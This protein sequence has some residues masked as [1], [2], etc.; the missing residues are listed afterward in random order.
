MTHVE[1][2]RATKKSQILKQTKR[3]AWCL[4]LKHLNQIIYKNQSTFIQ[5]KYFFQKTLGTI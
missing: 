5:L 3:G 4:K 1:E 2:T